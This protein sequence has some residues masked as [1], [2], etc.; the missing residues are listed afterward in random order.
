MT[1]KDWSTPSSILPM[2]LI[3]MGVLNM[4]KKKKREWIVLA[5]R[6]HAEIYTRH[7]VNGALRQHLRLEHPAARLHQKDQG[8]DRPGRGN[9]PVGKQHHSYSDH[10]DFPA[11]ESAAFLKEISREIDQAARNG[12][13]DSII[14]IALPKTLAM[15]K[16]EFSTQTNAKVAGEYA[17]NLVRVPEHELPQRIEKLR[18][19]A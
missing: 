10:A 8:T 12:E 2:Q 9:R 7:Y 18:E 17:K 1:V 4:L 11:A 14:L 6:A 13:L 5:D 16:S 3:L 15:I 19:S